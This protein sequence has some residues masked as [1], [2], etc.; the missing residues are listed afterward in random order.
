MFRPI[1]AAVV[2]AAALSLSACANW[3]APKLPHIGGSKAA[4]D[5]AAPAPKAAPKGVSKAGTQQAPG[6]AA[7]K[8]KPGQWAQSASDLAADPDIRF[9]SLPNGM[10]YAIRRNATPTGQA[11][12]RLRFD[13]GS[14]DETDAQQGLAH[15]LEHMAFNGSKAIPEGDMVKILERHGLAFGADTNAS[16]NYDETSYKL[17]LPHT[18]DD[19]VD[20]SLHIL[21]EVA[22]ELTI[23]PDAVDRERGVVMSEERTR[24]SPAYRVYKSRLGYV[25]QGQRPPLRHPIGKV[26]VL[27]NAP[28]SQIAAFYRDWYRPDRATIVAVGDFDPDVMEAKIKAA[29]SDWKPATASAPPE[30]GMGDV[31]KRGPETRLVIEPGAPATAQLIWVTPPDLSRDT[32]AKR[33]RL[34]VE[35]L[36]FA[37]INRRLERLARGENPPF[38]AAAAFRGDQFKAA[39]LTTFAVTMQPG[40]WQPA[41]AAIDQEQRRAAQYGVRQDELD[42]E[43]EEVRSA[44]K[45]QVAGAATRRTVDV[46]GD[47]EGSLGDDDVVTSPAQ[48]LALFE[49]TVKDLKAETVSASLKNAFDGAGPLVFMASPVDVPGDETA[50]TAALADSRKLAVTEPAAPTTV[51]WPYAD[52]GTPGAVAEQ[53]DVP[54][55]DTVFVR[56]KNG[57]RLTVKPTKFTDDEVLVKVRIGGGLQTLPKDRQSLGWAG[58]A[59]LEGGLAKIDSSDA[60][61]VLAG[62]VY[63]AAFGIED[64]AFV[65]S[66]G[67][68]RDDLDTQLQV[69]AAYATDPGWRPAAFKRIRAFGTTLNDQYD[70]TDSGVI[71]R[72]LSGLLHKGDRRWTFPA[73]AEI[74]GAKLEDLKAQV[75][76]GMA[77]GQIEVVIVG[78]ITPEKAIAAVAA[79]FG[80]LPPRAPTAPAPLAASDV[81]FPDPTPTPLI[82]THKGRADQATAFM[83]WPT[84][85]FFSSPQQA[86][87]VSILGQVMELRLLDELREKQGA[88][89]SPSVGYNAS[90][91]W[92]H[93]GY[94]SASEEAPPG[95][96]DSFFTDTLRIAADLR[97]KPITADELNR[98]KKPRLEALAKARQTNE[99]WLDKLSGAQADPRLLDSVRTVESGL[100]RVTI[101]DVQTTAR[102]YLRD[103]KAF[104]LVVRPAAGAAPAPS[105]AAPA[106]PPG[107]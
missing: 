26:D 4:P 18:D 104:K 50:V 24:D 7:P 71:S 5:A 106:A 89:Y 100:Q 11:A 20:T 61:R 67:T 46:A 17:D 63:G 72:E 96:M 12:L 77:T 56:F 103:D 79:T 36:G 60:Q 37:V 51:V 21:R 78:D 54:D 93:W 69:L 83:A 14:L 58:F 53:K 74:A 47:I 41:L 38:I 30:P 39:R 91:T 88:T 82:L 87:N 98:A 43:I 68:R 10:R 8:L 48:D 6:P 45:A 97:D 75:A 70:A 94:I 102:L 44:L 1:R 28:A 55:L 49:A 23:A 59:Y 19:T 85:D 90:L 31:A 40:A 80:A 95:K 107:K 62:K 15:F 99:Y 32:E 42:R 92:N 84:D 66:G 57:V 9:G 76:P 13:A 65:L 16:T 3:Q 27:A 25:F 73:R 2:F 35:R 29:F 34:W 101:G 33:R 52:F 64:T 81:G 86:R 105:T 22:S